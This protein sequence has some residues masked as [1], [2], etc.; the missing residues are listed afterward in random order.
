MCFFFKKNVQ[1]VEKI[2]HNTMYRKDEAW[3]IFHLLKILCL[4]ILKF[5]F[6]SLQKDRIPPRWY[7]TIV[8]RQ[9]AAQA[10]AY[11]L[12]SSGMQFN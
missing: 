10:Y 8:K 12:G 2:N 7:L 1:Y 4:N 9:H 6:L 11:L 5:L 3:N